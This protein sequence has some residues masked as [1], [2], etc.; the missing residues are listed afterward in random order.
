MTT[1]IW[2]KENIMKEID[3]LI[4]TIKDKLHKSILLSTNKKLAPLP[5]PKILVGG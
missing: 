4:C 2:K 5:Q 3:E 1:N